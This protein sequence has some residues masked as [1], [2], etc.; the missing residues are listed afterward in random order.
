[1]REAN[2]DKIGVYVG[3]P[4]LSQ[5][6]LL[7]APA[8]ASGFRFQSLLVGYSVVKQANNV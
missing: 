1:M 2:R 3:A 8:L 4:I 5:Q 7:A 6:A